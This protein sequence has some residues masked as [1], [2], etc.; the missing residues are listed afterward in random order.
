ME[1]AAAAAREQVKVDQRIRK[2]VF[3]LRIEHRDNVN[4]PC[5]MPN[6]I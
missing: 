1:A 6:T 4:E 2:T 5:A 3:L